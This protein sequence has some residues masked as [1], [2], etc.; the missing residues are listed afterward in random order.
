MRHQGIA[1]ALEWV[2]REENEEADQLSN[3]ITSSFDASR[4]V[5]V[6]PAAI[7]W[8]VMD[9]LMPA[10]ERLYKCIVEEKEQSRRAAQNSR[11]GPGRQP[12][13]K[14]LAPW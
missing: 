4:E 3:L 8:R 7:S 5:T 12:R 2:P 9:Q 14:G 1:L 13:R 6:D 10:A 11:R